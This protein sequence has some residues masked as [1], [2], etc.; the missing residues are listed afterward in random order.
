[1]T[2]HPGLWVTEFTNIGMVLR[3]HVE[4]DATAGATT[5]AILAIVIGYA[6]GAALAPAG[7]PQSRKG[8]AAGR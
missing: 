7:N 4:H 3:N 1:M 8:D 6:V 5:E 2:R